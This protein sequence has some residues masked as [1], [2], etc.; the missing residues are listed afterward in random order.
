TCVSLITAYHFHRQQNV[1]NAQLKFERW[2]KN[3]LELY[4]HNS[5][6]N[7]NTNT[8]ELKN[9][10][11][12]LQKQIPMLTSLVN[13]KKIRIDQMKQIIQDYQQPIVDINERNRL[14]KEMENVLIKTTKDFEFSSNVDINLSETIEQ[15]CLSSSSYDGN[16]QL[17][18]Q[19]PVSKIIAFFE[20]KQMNE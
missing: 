20:Q 12:Q 18:Q 2:C 14:R 9:D 7:N 15:K 3:E 17:L 8:C 6:T 1:L 5:T 13:Q 19:L 16:D 11:D 4:L 10:F